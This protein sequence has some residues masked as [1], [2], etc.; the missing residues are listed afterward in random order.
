[1]VNTLKSGFRLFN[2]FNLSIEA[3][4][5]DCGSTIDFPIGE[6]FHA[7]NG[8]IVVQ[9]REKVLFPFV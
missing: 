5:F 2:L 8:H 7:G 4:N 3:Y 9:S 6:V 1:M